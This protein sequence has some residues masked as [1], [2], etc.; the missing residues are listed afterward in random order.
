MAIRIFTNNYMDPILDTITVKIS[1]T[2]EISHWLPI[3]TICPHNNTVDLLYVTVRFNDGVFR[4][5]YAIRKQ[6]FKLAMFKKI[7]MEDLAI[8][9]ANN[10][11]GSSQVEV[12]LVTGRHI[13][14]INKCIES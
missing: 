13:V 1:Q 4:E 3:I 11:E 9:L 8:L 7:F 14:R 12:R 6:I 5:L 10:I 2:V